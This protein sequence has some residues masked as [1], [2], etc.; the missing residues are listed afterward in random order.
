MLIARPVRARTTPVASTELARPRGE[1]PA[2]RNTMSSLR[3]ARGAQ[4]K[5]RAQQRRNR[6]HLRNNV[7]QPKRHPAKS[8]QQPVVTNAD[9]VQLTDKL[10]ERA[11]AEEHGEH[12]SGG[13][14]D[15]AEEVATQNSHACTPP[16]GTARLAGTGTHRRQMPSWT[17]SMSN[18]A[19]RNNACTHQ[20]PR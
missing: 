19:T 4:S 18:A 8:V 16:P 2:A 5:Q 14:N 3:P 15:G 12:Q 17:I 1:T 13:A 7:R 6:Q 10:N 9:V 11:E 20:S